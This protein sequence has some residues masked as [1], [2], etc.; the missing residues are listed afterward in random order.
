MKG[1]C[2]V[3]AG[4][5][6]ESPPEAWEQEQSHNKGLSPKQAPAQA[7]VGVEAATP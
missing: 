2:Q 6:K 3:R 4:Q 7:T 5:R 1:L